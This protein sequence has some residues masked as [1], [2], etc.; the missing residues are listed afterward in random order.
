MNKMNIVIPVAGEGKRFQL[1]GYK[2]P[3]PFIDVLGRPMI[4]FVIENLQII[5]RE[6]NFI[7]IIRKEFEKY[8]LEK[9]L[10]KLLVHYNFTY[11]IITID[12]LTAGSLC[13]ILKARNYINNEDELLVANCDQWLNWSSFNF[14]NLV[15]ESKCDGAIITSFSDNPKWS[16][17]SLDF[18]TGWIKEVKEK[19]VI[20]NIA[21]TG[22]FYFKKGSD[23]VEAADDSINRDL[24]I[25]GEFYT[26]PVFNYLINT[27]DQK[28]LNYPLSN[29]AFWGI[30]TPSD[31]ERFIE[32]FKDKL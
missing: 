13:T 2:D 24:R 15:E 17:C 22:I 16:Y 10:K 21:N 8:N 20:S 11:N 4:E 31:L 18:S 29:H 6:L 28:I 5:E 32:H 30:G 23:F 1:A 25:N 12:L 7:I 27:K 14:I 9:I 19:E 26:A 3:K